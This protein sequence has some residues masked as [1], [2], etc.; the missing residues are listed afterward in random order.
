MLA[1]VRFFTYTITDA[2]EQPSAEGGLSSVD[3][4]K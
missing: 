1:D 4:A 2:N 3:A